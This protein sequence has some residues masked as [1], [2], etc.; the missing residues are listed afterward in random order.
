MKN[1]SQVQVKPL[2]SDLMGC[3]LPSQWQ[4]P[5]DEGGGSGKGGYPLLNLAR[6]SIGGTLTWHQPEGHQVSLWLKV[7]ANSVALSL[8]MGLV[9]TSPVSCH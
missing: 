7:C 2:V 1:L 6:L 5:E 8:V 9:P 4:G 3:S